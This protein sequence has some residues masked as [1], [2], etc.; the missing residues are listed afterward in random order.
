MERYML[1]HEHLCP[2]WETLEMGIATLVLA[3]THLNRYWKILHQKSSLRHRNKEQSNRSHR[4][5]CIQVIFQP[6]V[7][8]TPWPGSGAYNYN[9]STE[10]PLTPQSFIGSTFNEVTTGQCCLFHGPT[11]WE[12][13][14][15][16]WTL[17]SVLG[18]S[19]NISYHQMGFNLSG[20]KLSNFTPVIWDYFLSKQIC[21]GVSNSLHHFYFNE[22]PRITCILCSLIGS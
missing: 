6:V 11:F 21:I 5:F 3:Q 17:S 8:I 18:T 12:M 13:F 4:P 2:W 14:T 7:V 16:V 19:W 10:S 20:T 9:H 15:M 1:Q 22:S